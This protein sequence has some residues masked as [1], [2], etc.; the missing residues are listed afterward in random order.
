MTWSSPASW[1]GQARLVRLPALLK[2]RDPRLCS[3]WRFYNDG[4]S[5]LF[6]VTRQAT[7]V[8]WVSVWDKF[9]TVAFYLN[10]RAEELVRVSSLANALKQ[11]FLHPPEA[12][13]SAPSAWRCGRS[14]T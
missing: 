12:N 13:R 2:K 7:T 8:C 9:F 14:P 5:W 10:S 3:E 6:K 4:R 11:G 1:Q